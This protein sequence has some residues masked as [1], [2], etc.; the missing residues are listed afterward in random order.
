MM[1]WAE[2]AK[3]SRQSEALFPVLMSLDLLDARN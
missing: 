3:V 2:L 1:F